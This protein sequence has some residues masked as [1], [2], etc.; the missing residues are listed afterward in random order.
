MSTHTNHADRWLSILVILF[1]CVL[2]FLWIPADVETGIIE[3]VRSQ[4]NIGDAMAPT[5]AG[6]VLGLG[7]LML[8]LQSLLGHSEEKIGISVINLKFLGWL[9]GIVLVSLLVMRWLGPLVTPLLTGSDD[10]AIYRSLR[11]TLPWKY[12]G[13][14]SG[15]FIMIFGLMTFIQRRFSW[16]NFIVA[17]LAVLVLALIYDLPFDNLLLPPN[18]DV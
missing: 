5:I 11:D 7:G 13:Y 8:L 12:I 15:G 18:G 14:L 10:P 6:A 9:I 1:A 17:L 2:V 16:I 3:K 4:K